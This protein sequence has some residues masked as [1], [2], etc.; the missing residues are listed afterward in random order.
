MAQGGGGG[1]WS[2]LEYALRASLRLLRDSWA[3]R[4]RLPGNPRGVPASAEDDTGESPPPSLSA[5]EALPID[6]LL[7][8]M[9]FLEPRDL[10]HL[11]STSRYLR[12]T[13]QDPLLWRYFLTRDLHSWPAVDWK[14]LPDA[15]IFNKP[16]AELNDSATCDYMEAYKKCYSCCKRRLNSSQPIYGTVAS[17]LQSLITQAEPCFAMF[18]PGLEYL[19]ES[20][21]LKLMTSPEVLPLAGVPSRQIRGIGSG[22]TFHL[23]GQKFNILTLHSKTRKE[24]LQAKEE[25]TNPINK[26]FYE[27]NRLDGAKQYRPIEHVK[28]MCGLVDG[29]IYVADAEVPKRHSLLIEV[30]QMAAMLDP[31]LGPSDRPLLV[32]SCISYAQNERIPC[33]HLAHQLQLN[34]LG[35][36]WR[37]QDTEVATLTGLLDGIQWLLEQARRRNT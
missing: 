12:L 4:G 10:S 24:R 15:K 35:R 14:S 28:H 19:N 21:V 36:P 29:F 8:I 1:E 25:D 7:Y 31:A 26:M 23:N 30:A 6:V 11:G 22:L 5:L 37:V 13:V 16:F 32:L 2:R 3:Q 27:K 9:S 20:L 33:V 34:L 18:G 17:L